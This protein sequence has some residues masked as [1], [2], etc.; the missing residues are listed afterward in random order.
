MTRTPAAPAPNTPASNTIDPRLMVM[1][2]P[3]RS[4]AAIQRATEST[5]PKRKKNKLAA[6]LY[7][8]T[9][10][11]AKGPKGPVTRRPTI[12]KTKRHWRPG[13]LLLFFVVDIARALREIKHYQ[14]T[15]GLCLSQL[16]FARLVREITETFSRSIR[17]QRT[18]LLALQEV[19]EHI[20]TTYFELMYYAALYVG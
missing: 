6:P 15:T 11:Q 19:S 2:R 8:P 17:Y 14:K 18:A 12:A 9:G 20:L 4:V 5:K 1:A 3:P 10:R 16:P 13:S 7:K